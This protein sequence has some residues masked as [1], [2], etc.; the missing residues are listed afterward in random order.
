MNALKG[1]NSTKEKTNNRKRMTKLRVS[2]QTKFMKNTYQKT[3]KIKVENH[4]KQVFLTTKRQE[5]QRKVNKQMTATKIKI[6]W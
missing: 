1:R 3:I 5:K 6:K 2:H 4:N